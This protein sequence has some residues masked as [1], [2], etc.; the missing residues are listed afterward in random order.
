MY[1]TKFATKLYA[2]NVRFIYWASLLQVTK[3]DSIFFQF[4]NGI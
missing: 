2:T 1:L 4:N 3:W